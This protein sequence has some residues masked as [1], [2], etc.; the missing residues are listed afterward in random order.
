MRYAADVVHHSVRQGDDD[1]FTVVPIEATDA[2]DAARKTAE[3]AA[4]RRYEDAGTVGFIAATS[5]GDGWFRAVIGEQ[6]PSGDG[7]AVRGVSITIHVWPV[8]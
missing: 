5:R 7:I 8:D 2:A 4:A 6:R 1:R 3:I